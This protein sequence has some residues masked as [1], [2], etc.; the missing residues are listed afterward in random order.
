MQNEPIQKRKKRVVI[1]QRLLPLYRVSFFQKLERSLAE[2][3]VELLVIYGQS[4]KNENFGNPIFL[5]CGIEI[6]NRYFYFGKYFFVWQPV[7]NLIKNVDLIITEHASSN[8][9][10]IPLL[11]RRCFGGSKLAFW[12]HGR[13]FSP[14]RSNRLSEW[15]KRKYAMQADFWFT[16]ND[17]SSEVVRKLGY[18][19]EKM[20]SCNNSIDSVE[21][22]RLLNLIS[23]EERRN[24]REHY[25]VPPAAPVGVLCGRL[26]PDKGVEFLLAS[27]Q[28]IRKEQK[29]FHFFVV[30]DGPRSDLVQDFANENG[31][32][33]H[34]IGARYGREKA[35]IFSISDVHLFPG[36][37][38]LHVIESFS[39]LTPL[40]TVET[41]HGP[42]I[43]CL[44]SGINGMLVVKDEKE[45]ASTVVTLLQDQTSLSRLISGC[46]EAREQYTLEAM[47]D[48]FADGIY[49]ALGDSCV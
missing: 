38:G 2:S 17:L 33:F 34:W 16:Y 46:S 11:L 14:A 49:R 37:V 29:N 1:L 32:W 47:V 20:V 23:P 5:K 48:R 41:H 10:N 8:L 7:L 39:F 45:Y 12:G 35:E 26:S 6:K 44:Q 18:P 22:I 30:G 19:S 40:I 24:I 9:T 15:I 27:L 25:G 4:K 3:G 36:P 42:E 21:N 31:Q 43:A 13:C 28:L